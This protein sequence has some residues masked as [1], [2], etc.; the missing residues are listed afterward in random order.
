MKELRE[1]LLLWTAKD[2]SL[3]GCGRREIE[4]MRARC[5]GVSMGLPFTDMV[6][7]SKKTGN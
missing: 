4:R 6:R 1:M 7:P 5:D 2:I 3:T